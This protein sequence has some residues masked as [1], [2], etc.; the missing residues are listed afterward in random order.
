MGIRRILLPG[1]VPAVDG[2]AVRLPVRDVPVRDMN[3]PCLRTVDV[4]EAAVPGNP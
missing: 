3:R 1:E 4:F 2:P